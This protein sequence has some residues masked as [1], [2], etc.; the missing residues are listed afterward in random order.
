MF[1]CLRGIV[2]LVLLLVI[3]VFGY[4]NR[5]KIKSKLDQLRGREVVVEEV[6][7]PQLAEA[8]DQKLR[9]LKDGRVARVALSQRELQSLLQYKYRA[10]LPEFVDSPQVTLKGEQI[11]VK[12]RVPVD[13]LPQVSELGEAASF[14]PDTAEVGVSGK[15]IPIRPGRIAL[16][17][18]AVK[19]AGIPL[20]HRLVP[21]AL[22]RLGRKDEPGLPND[23]MAMPLPSGV[24]AA[25]VRS[26]SLIFIGKH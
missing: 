22:R 18:D 26:D 17:V 13:R 20:P 8:T 1:G 7:S 23:A 25:Y 21:N 16:A 5:D 12:A 11:E 6:A 4:L 9:D 2:S 3:V 15:F 10:L 19:A 14:L 24:T